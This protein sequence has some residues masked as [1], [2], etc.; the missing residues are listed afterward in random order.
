MISP[1]FFAQKLGYT[2]SQTIYD[3]T[4]GK[5]APSYDFFKRFM[6]SEYSAI[7]NIDWLI[8]GRGNMLYEF[9]RHL[10]IEYPRLVL[11]KLVKEGKVTPEV[12]NLP[13]NA[14]LIDKMLSMTEINNKTVR[15]LTDIIKEQ[16]E[17]IGRLKE[18]VSQAEKKKAEV[19]SNVYT[20]DTANVG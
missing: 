20:S 12:M 18:Q 7:Y 5:S 11:D 16:A 14:D 8:T 3:I 1:N 15:E 10:S 19:A 4:N 17:Q 2:R 9:D 13:Y 6:L